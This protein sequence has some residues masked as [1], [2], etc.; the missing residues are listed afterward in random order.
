[1]SRTTFQ[2][3]EQ[4]QEALYKSL[5]TLADQCP[6]SINTWMLPK[7]ESCNLEDK[8]FVCSFAMKKEFANPS[9]VVLHGGLSGVVFDTAMGWLSSIY[10]GCMTP[11]ISMTISYLRPIPI[12]EPVLVRARLDKPGSTVNYVSAAAYNA[13]NPEKFLATATGTYYAK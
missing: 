1:M 8:S 5:Y 7:L 11:T 12:T 6:N 2:T 9:G 13:G 4:M 10:A 3:A